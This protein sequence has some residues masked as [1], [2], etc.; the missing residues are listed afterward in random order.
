[1]KQ[2]RS[3]IWSVALLCGFCLQSAVVAQEEQITGSST[4]QQESDRGKTGP[5]TVPCFEAIDRAS[6]KQ[7][8]DKEFANLLGFARF[9][10]TEDVVDLIS[11]EERCT[12]LQLATD[13]ERSQRSEEHTSELQSHHDLVC[14]LLLEKKNIH[15]SHTRRPPD[16][17]INI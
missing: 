12:F 8:E 2:H 10:L 11:P 13:E 3:T 5:R 6:S 14:R 15:S 1:M 9:W 17:W 4:E 16:T 7:L